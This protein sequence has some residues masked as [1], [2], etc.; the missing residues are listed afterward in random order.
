MS[1]IPVRYRTQWQRWLAGLEYLDMPREA[2][3]LAGE[4]RHDLAR[5]GRALHVA[6]ALMAATA[7][8][9]GAILLTNNVKEYQILGLE[10]MRVRP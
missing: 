3:T 4:I 9:N 7:M 1:G 10:V 6:D 5:Q 8:V 2:A